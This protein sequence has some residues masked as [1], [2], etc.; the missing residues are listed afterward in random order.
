MQE[1]IY[2]EIK[3]TLFSTYT[4]E[5]YMTSTDMFYADEGTL[6]LI[7]NNMPYVAGGYSFIEFEIQ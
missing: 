4:L 1:Y 7:T 6:Y 5:E 2:E 3:K